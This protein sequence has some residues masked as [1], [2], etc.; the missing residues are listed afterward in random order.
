MWPFDSRG[1]RAPS[2]LWLWGFWIY[3]AAALA[4]FVLAVYA[5]TPL[6]RILRGVAGALI[7]LAGPHQLR[8]GKYKRTTRG[9]YT[10]WGFD[11]YL[12]DRQTG[13]S[14]MVVGTVLIAGAVVG[15]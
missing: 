2:L 6:D 5:P 14:A 11:S 12:V 3:V 9:P 15:V 10:M 13:W 7:F 1:E 8:V 4:A